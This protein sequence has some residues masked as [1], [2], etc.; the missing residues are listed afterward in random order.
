MPSKCIWPILGFQEETERAAANFFTGQGHWCWPATAEVPV[1]DG[2]MEGRVGAGVR[3]KTAE[4][5]TENRSYPAP[6]YPESPQ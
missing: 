4:K 2:V 1:S 3:A 6:P 5:Q